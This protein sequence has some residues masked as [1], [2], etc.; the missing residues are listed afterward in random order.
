MFQMWYLLVWPL[1]LWCGMHVLT[2][3]LSYRTGGQCWLHSTSYFWSLGVWSTTDRCLCRTQR[4]DG[5]HLVR[6]I[7]STLS[8]LGNHANCCTF[9]VQG[10][11][12]I[13][14]FLEQERSQ[15][16]YQAGLRESSK[17]PQ[18]GGVKRR[19]D[20]MLRHGRDVHLTW[21]K[22]FTRTLSNNVLVLSTK[23]KED[24]ESFW[25]EW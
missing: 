21:V 1:L 8:H 24:L 11:V 12:I 3:F 7:Q 17:F 19:L 15:S 9:N 25:W 22:L 23:S 5:F 2:V 13:E 18:C 10:E 20:F 4:V 6:Q 16:G 14:S